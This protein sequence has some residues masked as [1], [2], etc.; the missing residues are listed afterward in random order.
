MPASQLQTVRRFVEEFQSGHD[1]EIARQ[2]ISNDCI[3]WTPVAPFSPD[4]DGVMELFSMLFDAFPDLHVEIHDLIEA[5]DKVVTRKTFHGTHLG[6][7][8]GV[9]PTGRTVSWDAIDIVRVRDGQLVEH[10]NS[11]DALGLLTQLGAL[12]LPG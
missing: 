1:V 3:D 11:V 9:A 12:P 5:G 10:W 7:F 8:M 4:R 6:D 2:L